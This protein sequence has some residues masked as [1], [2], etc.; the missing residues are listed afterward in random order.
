MKCIVARTDANKKE[1][2]VRAIA[3]LCIFQ[4]AEEIA[5]F[6]LN[7]NKKTYKQ[8]IKIVTNNVI[9]DNS[10]S[11]KMNWDM[12]SYANIFTKELQKNTQI[13]NYSGTKLAIILLILFY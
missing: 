11:K 6:F 13:W 9:E 8:A 5:N 7:I 2:A 10:I 1:H 12:L 4:I 3:F